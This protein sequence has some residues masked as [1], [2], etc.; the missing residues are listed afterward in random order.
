MRNLKH[1]GIGYIS[2][3]GLSKYWGVSP[4]VDPNSTNRRWSVKF[5]EPGRKYNEKV[6]VIF[7]GGNF[8][9][10]EKVAAMIS[11]YFYENLKQLNEYPNMIVIPYGDD[12]E[13]RVLT[14]SRKVYLHK[15]EKAKEVGVAEDFT[16]Q[17]DI[18]T[19]PDIAFYTGFLANAVM[20]KYLSKKSLQGIRKIID[21]RLKEL[22]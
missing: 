3:R 13:F 22:E 9:P 21:E 12:Q 17:Q 19:D 20:Q 11:S 7:T 8:E 5:S 1:D 15:V 14:R 10:S 18:H 4:I 16:E 2:G 6:F